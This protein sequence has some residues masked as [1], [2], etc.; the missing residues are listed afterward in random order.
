MIPPP[1]SVLLFI[2]PIANLVGDD[3]AIV[4]A[5]VEPGTATMSIPTDKRWSMLPVSPA[6]TR[7]LAR[8][9]HSGVSETGMNA[10]LIPPTEPLAIAPPFLH[11]VGDQRQTPPWSHACPRVRTPSLR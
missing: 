3:A 6:T 10:P 7:R 9:N 2:T 5:D 8:F 11:G 4:S 1:P